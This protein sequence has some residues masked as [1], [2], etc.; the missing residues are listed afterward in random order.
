MS[1]S[2]LDGD[3]ALYFEHLKEVVRISYHYMQAHP[4]AK[5][6]YTYLRIHTWAIFMFLRTSTLNDID[7]RVNAESAFRKY[8]EHVKTLASLLL[9]A[10]EQRPARKKIIAWVFRSYS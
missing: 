4:I 6:A 5:S 2:E 10:R 8:P 9:G 3:W 1:A 7:S